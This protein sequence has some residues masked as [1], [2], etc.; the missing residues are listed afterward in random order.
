MR[1]PN[2]CINTI[3]QWVILQIKNDETV[4]FVFIFIICEKYLKTDYMMTNVVENWQNK[5]TESVNIVKINHFGIY[6]KNRIF[7]FYCRT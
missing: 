7:M 2:F 1:G 4:V 3:H 6:F 5:K